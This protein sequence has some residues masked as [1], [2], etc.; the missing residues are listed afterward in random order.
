MPTSMRRE[1]L[2]RI[3]EGHLGVEK[4]KRRACEA[5]Y[6][7]NMNC[8][9][10]QLI[11]ECAT[12]QKY[13]YKQAKEPLITTEL[14]SQPWQKVGSDIFHYEG[15]DYLLVIDYYSK[16][17]EMY[18]LP[19]TTSR[20]VITQLKSIFSRQGI[21]LTLVSDNGP[22][23]ASHEFQAFASDYEFKCITSS[24]LYPQA[25]GKAE[26]GVQIV[27]RLLKKKQHIQQH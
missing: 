17:P 3:H 15:K 11:R 21:P 6:W 24:P 19:S 25:N 20:A 18:L 7:P 10:D 4:S 23:Y 12:C 16:Y 1:M 9:I 13:H 26:K 5:L 8:D 14:P 2:A 27:K 22:P